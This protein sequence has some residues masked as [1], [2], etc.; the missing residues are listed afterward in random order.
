MA[1]TPRFEI[2]DLLSVTYSYHYG[3][4]TPFFEALIEPEPR[5]RI[6]RCEACDLQFCPPRHHCQQCWGETAWIDHDGRGV[7]ESIVW[8]YWIPIDSP[9]REWVD[10]PYAYA[11]VRL[12][13][14]RNLLRTRVIGLDKTAS[15]QESTGRRGRLIVGPNP[16]GHVGDLLFEIAPAS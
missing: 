16:R 6:S 7:A 13:G 8:A 5:L 2:P 3:A 9:A 15:L 14:C 4:I 11:A 1:N 10:P 12:D